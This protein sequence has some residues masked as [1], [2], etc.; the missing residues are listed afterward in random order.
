ME[1]KQHE[2]KLGLTGRAYFTVTKILS[3]GLTCFE[4]N[5]NH[6]NIGLVPGPTTV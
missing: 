2:Q 3:N 1:V 4:D 6:D 5:Q